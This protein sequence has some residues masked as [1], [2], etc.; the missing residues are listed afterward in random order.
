M[1][2]IK[3]QIEESV[4]KIVARR[5][6]T[7]RERYK[8][9][10]NWIRDQ[11]L[12]K[13]KR[14]DKKCEELLA[15]ITDVES[16]KVRGEYVTE[17]CKAVREQRAFWEALESIA[18]CALHCPPVQETENLDYDTYA[19]ITALVS[20]IAEAKRADKKAKVSRRASAAKRPCG[21]KAAAKKPRKKK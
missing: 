10:V 1:T 13:F 21:L 6:K 14:A 12:S 17:Y 8:K 19:D 11:V 4:K 16:G 20:R 15:K 3:A 18:D 7:E 9:T 2:P 5:N